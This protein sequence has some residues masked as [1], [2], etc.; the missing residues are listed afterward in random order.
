VAADNLELDPDLLLETCSQ[1]AMA[2]PPHSLLVPGLTILGHP[3]AARVGE[4]AALPELAAGTSVLLSRGQPLFAAAGQV[5]RRPLSDPCLSRQPVELA[6]GAEAG[7]VCLRVGATRT[8]V[9]VGG[10]P[11][12][13]GSEREIAAAEVAAGTVLLLGERVA[14][15]LSLVEP[16]ATSHLPRFGLIGE[17]P[18]ML[19]LRRDIQQ[20]AG[21]AA[22]A[23]VRGE[24]GTGKELVARALHEAG[25]R[26]GRPFLAVNIGAI[27]PTLAAAELFG[28]TRGAFTGADR[29]R[30][31]YFRQAEKGTLFLDEIG[32]SSAEIQI[33]LLRAL[34]NRE[35]QPV[36]SSEVHPVDVRLIAATDARLE[37]AVA[38]GRFRA[39]LL[40]RLSGCEIRLPPLRERREDIGRLLYHFLA[41]ELAAAGAAARL[42]TAPARGRPWLP[43]EVVASLAQRDWPGNIRQLRNL[44]R[45]LAV[46]FRNAPEAALTPEA[47]LLLA[48]HPADGPVADAL[49]T[50]GAPSAPPWPPAPAAA[51]AV[52][53]QPRR[54]YRRSDEV[55][56]D[57]LLAVLRANR[58][59]LQPA[60]VQLGIAR[61]SLYDR[62]E[63]SQRFRKAADLPRVEIEQLLARHGGSLER[64]ADEL[65]VSVD[66]LKRRMT[67][68]GFAGG[69]R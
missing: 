20:M 67:Q 46:S 8:T 62:I 59:R 54:A 68:L 39:P 40:Y 64:M 53:R 1:E 49:P 17:S 15:L 5:S 58:W 30:P 32:E 44:A 14:L 28:A 33:L 50:G 27:P 7:A 31:G 41:V 22:P 9:A 61:T 34:E 65:E 57:E 35:V 38:A 51:A 25:P 42:G 6:P 4:Q 36:G 10:A 60:A 56:D 43:A 18:A 52:P 66:G 3:D 16:L 19:R 48:P 55:S 13:A 69:R 63:S 12:S 23:L 24:T 2:L 21:L 29:P 45:H 11:V 37:E 47:E 26:R